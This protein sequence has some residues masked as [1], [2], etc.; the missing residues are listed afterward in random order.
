MHIDV[1]F[2]FFV[3]V[4][5]FRH[6]HICTPECSDHRFQKRQTNIQIL[7]AVIAGTWELNKVCAGN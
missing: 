4:C 2:L 3:C 6:A 5:V 1:L 7:V